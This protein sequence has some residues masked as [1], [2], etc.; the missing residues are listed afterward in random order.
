MGFV[1]VAL[2]KEIPAGAM[3][4]IDVSG[5]SVLLANV[6]GEYYA[7][8]NKCTHR[9]CKLSAGVLNG[10]IVKCPCHRSKFNVKTGEV[11]KGPA[12]KPEPKYSVRVDEE[13]ILVSV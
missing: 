5:T 6:D 13:Q 11:V 8:G 2:K 12:T 3:M 7:I 4:Q 9:R 1:K 10:E